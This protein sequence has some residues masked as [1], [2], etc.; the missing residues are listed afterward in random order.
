MRY[1][2]LIAVLF[3]IGFTVG[4]FG[5]EVLRTHQENTFNLEQ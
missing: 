3:A 5:S 4:Y 1:V 2:I